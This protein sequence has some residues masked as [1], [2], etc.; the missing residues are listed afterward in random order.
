MDV[1]R[2]LLKAKYALWLQFWTPQLKKSHKNKRGQELE[3]CRKAEAEAEAAVG[4]VPSPRPKPLKRLF[5][6]EAAPTAASGHV[7][8]S[9][10]DLQRELDGV[11][12]RSMVKRSDKAT[13]SKSMNHLTAADGAAAAESGSEGETV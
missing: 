12:G 4:S 5:K 9:V 2:A 11:R 7:R 6:T 8:P 10:S 3:R 1:G 13:H